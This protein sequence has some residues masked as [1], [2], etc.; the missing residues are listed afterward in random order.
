[1]SND[2]IEKKYNFIDN[3]SFPEFILFTGEDWWSLLLNSCKK[4]E[5][6]LRMINDVKNFYEEQKFRIFGFNTDGWPRKE[7]YFKKLLKWEEFEKCVNRCS[8]HH[9]E[10]DFKSVLN[11][12]SMIDVKIY[13]V[14]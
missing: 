2:L 9:F 4:S 5:L 8:R 13:Q 10:F 7:D 12:E 6:Y 1:M 11:N 14:I 3:I